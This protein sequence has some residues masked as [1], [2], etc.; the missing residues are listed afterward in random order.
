[1][2]IQNYTK[3]YTAHGIEEE[4]TLHIFSIHIFKNYTKC[5]TTPCPKKTSQ[6]LSI[7]S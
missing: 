6:M 7:V 2:R 3:C 4:Q 5:Q 1:M